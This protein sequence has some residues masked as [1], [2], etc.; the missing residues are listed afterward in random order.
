MIKDTVNNNYLKYDDNAS[1]A[2]DFKDMSDPKTHKRR[3][4]F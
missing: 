1:K 2:D 4:A 3:A